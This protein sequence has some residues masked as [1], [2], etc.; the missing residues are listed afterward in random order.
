MFI[1]DLDWDVENIEHIA[2]H[3]IEPDEVENVCYGRSLIKRAGENKHTV[4]GQTQEGCYLFVVVA[5]KGKGIF[6]VITARD[7]TAAE[8]RR[9]QRQ[10]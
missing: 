1:R 10:K 4:L 7:M 9:F 3:H 2:A 5:H 6:R 8:R